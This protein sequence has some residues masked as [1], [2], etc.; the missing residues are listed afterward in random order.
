MFGPSDICVASM[1]W[2]PDRKESV[3][4]ASLSRE[5]VQRWSHGKFI[6]FIISTNIK[7]HWFKPP[8]DV[9]RCWLLDHLPSG[10]FSSC[11]RACHRRGRWFCLLLLRRVVVAGDLVDL[12]QICALSALYGPDFHWTAARWWHFLV[13]WQGYRSGSFWILFI[14]SGSAVAHYR[15]TYII[16]IFPLWLFGICA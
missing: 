5:K 6:K 12:S 8:S 1:S 3:R 7:R 16:E 14:T 11:P 10:L 4:A 15:T 13:F 2:R 9:L